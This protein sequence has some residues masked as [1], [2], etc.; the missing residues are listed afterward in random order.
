MVSL[1]LTPAAAAAA[2]DTA[3]VAAA[4]DLSLVPCLPAV[5]EAADLV[6]EHIRSRTVSTCY[7]R[8][9]IA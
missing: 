3:D 9:T 5:V 6:Q 4:V 1:C 7:V 8:G 2:S